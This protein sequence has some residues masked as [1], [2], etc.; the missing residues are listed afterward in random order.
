MWANFACNRVIFGV[1]FLSFEIEQHREN[2]A[3][4]FKCSC[5]DKIFFF[6][7]PHLGRIE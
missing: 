1:K 6:C 7:S 5:H 3:M 4:N 2:A